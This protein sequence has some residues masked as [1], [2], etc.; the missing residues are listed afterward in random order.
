MGR[1]IQV[2]SGTVNDQSNMAGA[3]NDSQSEG[4]SFERL[5]LL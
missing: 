2:Q 5:L 3:D 1:D 4:N